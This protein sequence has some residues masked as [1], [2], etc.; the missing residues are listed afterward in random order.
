MAALEDIWRSDLR[1][2]PLTSPRYRDDRDEPRG[3]VRFA[4]TKRGLATEQRKFDAAAVMFKL[5]VLFARMLINAPASSNF[6]T[7]SVL[8][9]DAATEIAVAP[10]C[11]TTI[12]V[13]PSEGQ[14]HTAIPNIS[15]LLQRADLARHVEV[16]VRSEQEVEHGRESSLCRNY[17]W[18]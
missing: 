10:F 4:P 13:R 16:S 11:N 8:P 17:Q 18:C 9:S 12:R 14:W 1:Q 15:R 7:I 6:F 2:R 5:T 3:T